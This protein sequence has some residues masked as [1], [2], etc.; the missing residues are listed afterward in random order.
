MR[1][2]AIE[3]MRR[4]YKCEYTRYY[5]TGRVGKTGTKT[6]CVSNVTKGS[7]IYLLD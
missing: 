7:G 6:S 2:I 3:A 4:I 1:S 5:T